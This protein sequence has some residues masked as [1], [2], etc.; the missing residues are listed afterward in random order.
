M[1][2]FKSVCTV[3][4]VLLTELKNNRKND[5]FSFVLFLKKQ[6][7]NDSQKLKKLPTFVNETPKFSKTI[8]LKNDRFIFSFFLRRFYN[9]AI[10]FQKVKPNHPSVHNTLKAKRD[11]TPNG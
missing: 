4:I 2:F 3:H 6:L 1:P 10:V 11:S 7:K 8:F 9:E 5:N